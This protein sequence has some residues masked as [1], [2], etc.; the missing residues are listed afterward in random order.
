MQAV[1]CT[2]TTYVPVTFDVEPVGIYYA[3]VDG[4][5]SKL[6]VGMLELSV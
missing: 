1:Q 4:V 5:R 3:T 6:V 2:T